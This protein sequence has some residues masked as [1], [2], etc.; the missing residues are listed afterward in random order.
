M[1]RGK[2]K[3][4]EKGGKGRWREMRKKGQKR[5]RE[6]GSGVGQMAKGIEGELNK[7]K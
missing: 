7:T 2:Q 4:G 3:E 6:G 1:E 5:K